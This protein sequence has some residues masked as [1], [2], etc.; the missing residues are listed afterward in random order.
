MKRTCGLCGNHQLSCLNTAAVGMS[1][2]AMNECHGILVSRPKVMDFA[3]ASFLVTPA[4]GFA[5]FLACGP[6]LIRINTGIRMKAQFDMRLC[7]IYD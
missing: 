7:G 2:I 5:R 1:P 6:Q 4:N 3:A